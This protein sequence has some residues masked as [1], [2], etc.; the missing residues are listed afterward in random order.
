LYWKGSQRFSTPNPLL[1]AELPPSRSG[2]PGPHPTHPCV[3]PGRGH[4]QLLW[5]PVAGWEIKD[6]SMLLMLLFFQRLN[7]YNNI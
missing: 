6:C 2:C 1:W 4:P 3:P 7:L 5:Q